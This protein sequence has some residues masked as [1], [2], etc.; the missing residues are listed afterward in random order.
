MAI[1]PVVP[2][3]Y[4][5]AKL[6]FAGFAARESKIGETLALITVKDSITSENPRFSVYVEQLGRIV[7]PQ[8]NINIELVN[9]A[10]III[11]PDESADVYVNNFP[12]GL[13]A[14]PADGVSINAGQLIKTNDLS[15]I[16]STDFPGI[17]IGGNDQVFYLTRRGFRFGFYFNSSKEIDLEQMKKDIGK[18]NNE[19][20][21]GDVVKNSI[22]QMQHWEKS[23]YD[24]YIITEGETDWKHLVKA[25]E[26][27][28]EKTILVFNDS[29]IP[30]GDSRLLSNCEGL[31][32]NEM[33]QKPIICIFDND[34][35]KVIAE[36]KKRTESGKNYQ[37]WGNNVFSFMLPKPADR[38]QYTNIS[39]EMLYSDSFLLTP[40][41]TGKRLYFSSEIE[42]V[43]SKTTNKVLP[44]RIVQSKPEEEFDKKIESEDVK[45]IL[46]DKG[47]QVAISKAVFA[48]QV[49]I[50]ERILSETDVVN[51]KDIFEVI[52]KILSDI[53][54]N[55]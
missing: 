19:L 41:K 53:K 39:I 29:T 14:R 20:V 1:I 47:D 2:T 21:L 50:G 9:R 6:S 24:A 51:F 49:F 3:P 34:N 52:K 8:I 12:E 45:S 43:V 26:I 5:I 33:N 48:D 22:E 16:V 30:R 7:F 35:P 17:E 36:L 4:K 31:S 25:S 55:K 18:L 38:E 27:L 15:E 11:K 46:N 42:K 40:D 23:N 13:Q 37:N 10:L 44:P 28:K 54:S 32:Q